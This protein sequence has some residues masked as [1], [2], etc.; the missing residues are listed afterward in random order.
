M[1][2]QKKLAET[3]EKCEGEFASERLH[4]HF[5]ISVSR[6]NGQCAFGGHYLLF[7]LRRNAQAPT[8]LNQCQNV[9]HE[10]S[11]PHFMTRFK[12][13]GAATKTEKITRG[14]IRK[15]G[16]SQSHWSISENTKLLLLF[17]GAFFCC[18][19]IVAIS[20]QRPYMRDFTQIWNCRQN[21]PRFWVMFGQ[22]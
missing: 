2:L 21:C 22:S 12:R 20:A 16:A 3:H 17:F 14:R 1:P 13:N 5:S 15:C 18:K 19:I 4:S 11:L 10:L 9:V 6:K 7:F 8:H